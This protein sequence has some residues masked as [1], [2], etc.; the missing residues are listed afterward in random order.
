MQQVGIGQLR[1]YQRP[2][3]YDRNVSEVGRPHCAGTSHVED[4]DVAGVN[5]A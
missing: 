5:F 4:A 1:L 3:Q 2:R